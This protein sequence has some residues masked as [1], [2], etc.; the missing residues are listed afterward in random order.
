MAR[1]VA[2]IKDVY[3]DS[4]GVRVAYTVATDDGI[5]FSA[6]ATVSLS[7]TIPQFLTAARQKVARD[8]ETKGSTVLPAD[9]VICGGPA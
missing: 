3:S 2:V 5:N 7:M 1:A 8:C 9:V 6:D 4:S